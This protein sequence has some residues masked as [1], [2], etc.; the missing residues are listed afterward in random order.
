M[1]YDGCT[2]STTLKNGAVLTEGRLIFEV[3]S[4][5]SFRCTSGHLVGESN[6]ANVQCT[7]SDFPNK[8][9]D[10]R[11]KFVDFP[12]KNGCTRGNKN[13][14]KYFMSPTGHGLEA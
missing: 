4:I 13:Y 5:A 2:G 14:L 10:Y 11:W 7:A 8:S 12:N 1:K 3:G 9:R 6:Y